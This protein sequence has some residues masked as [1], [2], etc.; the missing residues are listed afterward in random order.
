MITGKT[1]DI[2]FSSVVI[3]LLEVWLNR[4]VYLISKWNGY[5]G[6]CDYSVSVGLCGGNKIIAIFVY[7]MLFIIAPILCFISLFKE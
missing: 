1:F 3:I 5:G 7:I 6:R 2:F 4:M